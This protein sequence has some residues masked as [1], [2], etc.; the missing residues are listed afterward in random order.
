[1]TE[2][3]EGPL[4]MHPKEFDAKCLN[5][6]KISNLTMWHSERKFV[7]DFLTSVNSMN[8]PFYILKEFRTGYGIP[9]ILI[10]EY[11]KSVIIRRKKFLEIS[12]L[13]PFDTNCAYIMAY[14]AENCWVKLENLKS[15]FNIHSCSIEIIIENLINRELVVKKDSMIKS[16]P[17][18][19]IFAINGIIAI[20]AKLRKWKNAIFQ[21]QRHLWFTKNSNILIPLTNGIQL[22]KIRYFCN[23][24]DVNL[25]TFNKNEIVTFAIETGNSAPYNTYLAWLLNELLLE[26]IKNG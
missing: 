5:T 13:N 1:M 11:D 25:I 15:K 12:E 8:K 23:K 7:D 19:E 16:V 17:Q 22:N 26:E 21:A 24:N 18:K 9:D 4:K 2:M 20:E 14:L 3:V 6:K 10:I